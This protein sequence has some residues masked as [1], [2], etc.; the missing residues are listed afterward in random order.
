MYNFAQILLALVMKTHNDIIFLCKIQDVYLGAREGHAQ[1]RVMS[2][3]LMD[4]Y[5][6]LLDYTWW[7]V[8]LKLMKGQ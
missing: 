1:M 4:L 7:A 6:Y 5:Y 3:V 8:S 2:E